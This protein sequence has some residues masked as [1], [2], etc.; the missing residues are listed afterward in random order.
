MST[1]LTCPF[2]VF[3]GLQVYQCQVIQATQ[4]PQVIQDIVVNQAI[5]DIRVPQ[6][7]VAILESVVTV[8]SVAIVVILE[9]QVTV[10]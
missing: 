5:L 2:K 4:V 9:Y 7:I 8:Q 6:A 10:Q 3:K 1:L